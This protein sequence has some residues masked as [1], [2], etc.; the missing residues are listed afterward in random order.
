M[1][2]YVFLFDDYTALDAFGPVEVLSKVPDM[3]IRYISV[4]GG[5]VINKQEMQV[6]TDPTSVLIG[7]E[8]SEEKRLLLV[9]GGPGTRTLIHIEAF[10]QALGEA[11]DAA[12]YVLT[13]CTG[14]ALAAGTGR[15]NGIHATSNKNAF[16]WVVSCGPDVLWEKEPR[17][18]V[19]GKY[20]TSA[21]ISAGIDMA[22]GF[23]ADMFDEALAD[24]ICN[25]LEYNW[26]KN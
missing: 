2:L 25:I 10:L 3:K 26:Q 15:L 18:V 1:E 22:L 4:G 13:V 19:D 6:M 11:M 17:W 12:N 14:S 5:T 9:P 8:P 23:V 20:Y 24:K 16:N 21:G 7:A